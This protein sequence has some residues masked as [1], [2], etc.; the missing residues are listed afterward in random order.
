[1]ILTGGP[2][3]QP[4]FDADNTQNVAAHLTPSSK[5]SDISTSKEA[6]A[7]QRDSVT[8]SASILSASS[9]RVTSQLRPV[10]SSASAITE[11]LQQGHKDPSSIRYG[12]P[13]PPEHTPAPAPSE[14]APTTTELPR[15]EQSPSSVPYSPH[16]RAVPSEHWHSSAT[17]EPPRQGHKDLSTAQH[18]PP[19][20][21]ER[22]ASRQ[23]SKNPSATSVTSHRPLAPPEHA[24]TEPPSW[25]ERSPSSIQN[26]PPVPPERTHAM[27][28]LF[29]SK[30]PSA[31]PHRL[32]RTESPT[33]PPPERLIPL[34]ARSK[35]RTQGSER[36]DR[37][38]EQT[39]NGPLLDEKERKRKMGS[40]ELVNR[41]KDPANP[42]PNLKAPPDSSVQ[43][44]PSNRGRAHASSAVH[45]PEMGDSRESLEKVGSSSNP[46]PALDRRETHI[47]RPF[48]SAIN[49][50][51]RNKPSIVSHHPRLT[52]DT[53][54]LFVSPIAHPAQ[55][56]VNPPLSKLET[57]PPEQGEGSPASGCCCRIC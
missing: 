11:P 35:S 33:L 40:E 20:P 15:Q 17:T 25:Q 30:F 42:E 45:L 12:L 26:R 57:Q 16:V 1:M 55:P 48:V 54:S 8:N 41:V 31:T 22:V 43:L 29:S 44:P 36:V 32:K 52:A 46:T 4:P 2:Q 24:T 6:R 21:P 37:G 47:T 7:V 5:L 23:G 50:P 19:T 51:K 28:E 49:Q 34:S 53:V 14:H 39:T 38:A 27:T 10:T 9:M 18:R 13:A 3:L 56:I